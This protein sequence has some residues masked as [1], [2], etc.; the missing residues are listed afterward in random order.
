MDSCHSQL[1]ISKK[2]NA[3]KIPSHFVLLYLLYRSFHIAL[4]E[5]NTT[6][7]VIGAQY[8]TPYPGVKK[9]KKNPETI[10]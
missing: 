9:L 1:K 7:K 5:S 6:E 3:F 2:I 8:S 4:L 10:L